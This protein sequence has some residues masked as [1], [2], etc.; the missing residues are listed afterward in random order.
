MVARKR[1]CLAVFFHIVT[2]VRNSCTK[3]MEKQSL[4]IETAVCLV[5]VVAENMSMLVLQAFILLIP[6]HLAQVISPYSYI[7]VSYNN[8]TPI[9]SILIS[10]NLMSS[11]MAQC[12]NVL[13][14]TAHEI[15][16][17]YIILFYVLI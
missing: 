5:I 7:S 1:F 8:N 15:S 11:S 2:F 6:L 10:I 12:V 14:A 17:T 13:A 16:R 3:K 9:S 4:C